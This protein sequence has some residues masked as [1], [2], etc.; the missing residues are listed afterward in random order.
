MD[1]RDKVESSIN[2]I[3]WVYLATYPGFMSNLLVGMRLFQ[4][5]DKQNS[6]L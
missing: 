4:Y 2:E 3:L 1:L 5:F 6:F